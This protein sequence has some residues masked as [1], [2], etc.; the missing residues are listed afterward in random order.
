MDVDRLAIEAIAPELGWVVNYRVILV[1]LAIAVG[2][3]FLRRRR[4][5]ALYVVMFPIV[6]VAWK[7]PRFF[8][9]R[10][11]WALFLGT[12]QAVVAISANLR[13]NIATKALALVAAIVIVMTHLEPLI[14]AG[15]IYLAALVG[16]S[17]LRVFRKTFS[18]TPF[19]SVQRQWIERVL[20]SPKFRS[21]TSLGDELRRPGIERYS[22]AEAQQVAMTMSIAISA[23]KGLQLWA[24]QV[25]RYRR[26]YSPALVFSAISFAWI[27]LGTVVALGLLN[28]AIFK[29]APVEYSVTGQPTLLS[30]LVYALTTLALSQG[31]GIEA[32]GQLA[33]AIQLASGLIGV[34]LLAS[35]VL[36]VVLAIKRQHDEVA[37]TELVNTLK[38]SARAQE[39]RFRLEYEVSVDEAWRRLEDLGAS[40]AALITYV[41]QSIPDEFLLDAD[42][43]V[44]NAGEER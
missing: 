35:I 15:G 21:F 5:A 22:D 28:L 39:A 26:R 16:W 38:L 2:A 41:T 40:F 11:S 12:L 23:T 19:A 6:V 31:G 8:Y 14:V 42:D 13:Y 10:R 9:A 32:V 1:L 25:D 17:F 29:V 20:A 7:I 33:L 36:N 30:F 43:Q 44:P 3:V 18:D 37:T 24:Y 34:L 4:L 27:F